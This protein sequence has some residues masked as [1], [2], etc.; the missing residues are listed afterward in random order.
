MWLFYN[1]FRE[2]G[3]S[4]L[5]IVGRHHLT[6]IHRDMSFTGPLV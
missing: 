3:V 6:P 5:H 2:A 1:C 4:E